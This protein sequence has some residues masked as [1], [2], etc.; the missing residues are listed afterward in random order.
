MSNGVWGRKLALTGKILEAEKGNTWQCLVIRC[1]A[2]PT[3]IYIIKFT[4]I[5][6]FVSEG[7][8]KAPI[9]GICRSQQS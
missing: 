4:P 8:S 7:E 5:G 3:L 6:N 1:Q 2:A 9:E